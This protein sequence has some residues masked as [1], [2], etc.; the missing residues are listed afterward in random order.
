MTVNELPAAQHASW[1]LCHCLSSVCMLPL[2]WSFSF[3]VLSNNIWSPL[4]CSLLSLFCFSCWEWHSSDESEVLSNKV[5]LQ[6]LCQTDKSTTFQTLTLVCLVIACPPIFTLPIQN[7]TQYR[8]RGSFCFWSDGNSGQI[9]LSV[10]YILVI[11]P[12]TSIIILAPSPV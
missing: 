12:S 1:S 11:V 8:L 4:F 10:Q 5:H 2:L 9:Q 6:G 3:S 7:E